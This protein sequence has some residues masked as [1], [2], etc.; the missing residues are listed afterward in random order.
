MVSLLPLGVFSQGEIAGMSDPSMA[1]IMQQKFGAWGAV[2]VNVGVI[3][4]VL[5]SWLVWMLMLGQMPLFAARDGIFPKRFTEQNK[6]GA[7]S[8]SLLWTTIIIQVILILCHFTSGNAWNTMISITSVMAMPCYLLC[9]MFLWKV[10]VKEP[11]KKGENGIRFSRTTGLVTGIIGTIF[12]L[13]LVYAAGLNYLM[14]AA[15]LYA[16][17]I[18]LFIIGR[19][20]A[21]E[22]GNILKLF[23]TP[24]KVLAII[25]IVLGIIGIIYS[26]SS[27]VF[28]A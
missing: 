5:S 24:E 10:A 6:K 16:I 26:I 9:A 23:T 18:P 20:Q 21:G 27:G 17:G 2:M 14:I 22:K 1:A 7:P 25:V 19:R 13:Y 28:T 12:A 4:S 3:I 8:F 15:F 11:W